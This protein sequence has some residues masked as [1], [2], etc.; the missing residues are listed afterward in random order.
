RSRP[1]RVARR[2]RATL[3]SN[4]PPPV[5]ACGDSLTTGG[6]AVQYMANAISRSSTPVRPNPW[7]HPMATMTQR[8]SDGRLFI[9]GAF[10]EASGGGATA[11]LEKATGGELGRQATGSTADLELAIEGA[12]R[13]QPAW[14]ATGYDER[15]ALLR[16]VARFLDE[17][18]DEYAD[19]I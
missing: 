3:P 2:R 19:L 6:P 16:R 7:R 5:A 12:R 13:A 10:R 9:D 18:A 14:A 1:P 15:A 17:R 11:I 8:R 4:A